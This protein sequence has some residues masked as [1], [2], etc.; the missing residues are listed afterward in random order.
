MGLAGFLFVTG[1]IPLCLYLSASRVRS[2]VFCSLAFLWPSLGSG[3]TAWVFWWVERSGVP[4]YQLE[5]LEF[6]G[7]PVAW[8]GWPLLAVR[9]RLE[10][11]TPWWQSK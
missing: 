11:L 8:I 10:R 1:V 5:G 9:F 3:Y 2:G 7:F 6:L 4:M